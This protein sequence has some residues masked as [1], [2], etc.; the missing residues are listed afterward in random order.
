MFRQSRRQGAN[1]VA[2]RQSANLLAR[3]HATV[4]LCALVALALS[5]CASLPPPG[6]RPSPSPPN[7]F[8]TDKSFTAPEV[9]WP[10]DHWW[11]SYKDPQLDA[12]IDEGLAGAPDM[13]I[14]A[15][16][17][18]KARAVARQSASA[19][20]PSLSADGQVGVAKQSY[21][22]IFPEAFAPHG[23]KDYAQATLDLSWD[24]DFWGKTRAAARAAH[25]DAAAQAAEAADTRLVLS[26]QIASD[27]ATLAQLYAELDAARDAVEVRRRTAELTSGRFQKGLE[28]NGAV[29]RARSGLATA[30][31]DLADLNEQIALNKTQIALLIGAGPD[32][33]LSISRPKAITVASFGLPPNLPLDLIGRRP[34]IIAARDR[35]LAAA[36]RIKAAK[37]AFYPDLNLSADI[38]FQ[39]LGIGNLFKSG[40]DYGT[41]GPAVSLPIFDGGNLT[42]AYREAEADYRIAVAQYDSAL[43]QALSEVAQAAVS[44]RALA[45]RLDETRRAEGFAEDAYRT[46]NNRYKGGLATYLDVLTAEDSLITS[47]RAVADL[48]TRAFALDISLTRALGGGFQS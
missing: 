48:E 25:E 14:A 8:S 47:R 43:N 19:L 44:E 34:D 23:W 10:S 41:A 1:V 31:A 17:V 22:Y 15:A 32:R 5:A 2:Q 27:Y 30:R 33:G 21:R 40:A 20:A 7:A 29:E 13:R 46:A 45:E 36:S 18:E 6:A 16:R 4:L 12:L 11:R 3:R 28:N 9:S 42:G 38:G 24:V 39:A 37:G 26:T 35:A